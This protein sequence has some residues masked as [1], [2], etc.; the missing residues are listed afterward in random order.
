MLKPDESVEPKGLKAVTAFLKGAVKKLE[1]DIFKDPV[2]AA[3]VDGSVTAKASLPPEPARADSPVIAATEN[4]QNPPAESEIPLRAKGK[5]LA[6][7]VP[8]KRFGVMSVIF[9]IGFS[10]WNFI[11]RDSRKP[12]PLAE[13]SMTGTPVVES[14]VA[15]AQ[16]IENQVGSSGAWQES[17]VDDPRQAEVILT[18]PKIKTEELPLYEGAERTREASAIGPEEAGLFPDSAGSPPPASAPSRPNVALAPLPVRAITPSSG[19]PVSEPAE[20][21]APSATSP[22]PD[23]APVE[24][25]NIEP[26]KV[27]EKVKRGPSVRKPIAVMPDGPLVT[28]FNQRMLETR[29]QR[30]EASMAATSVSVPAAQ[31]PEARSVLEDRPNM[32]VKLLFRPS[33]C[34]TCTEGALLESNGRTQVVAQG[35]TYEGWVVKI[36]G[37]RLTLDNGRAQFSYLPER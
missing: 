36:S 4:A 16:T 11:N 6:E 10:A 3:A 5:G 33:G 26:P 37:D 7:L 25:A 2:T 19:A 24:M 34:P 14:E 17:A 20:A 23:I 8:W 32:K 21:S 30:K 35:D 22:K 28:E 18:G 15:T 12:P 9:L 1:P 13:V 29:K 31:A 27:I